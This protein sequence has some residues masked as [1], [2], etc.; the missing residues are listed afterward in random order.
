MKNLQL[1]SDERDRQIITEGYDVQHD[2][3][4]H[5]N[6]L[7]YAAIA[8]ALH[9]VGRA[10]LAQDIWPFSPSSYKPKNRETDLI[11]AAAL[12]IA[13]LDRTE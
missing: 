5:K 11:R 6:D 13:E 2:R 12:I 3:N 1:V 10:R 9:A 8:Y 4:H 7:A